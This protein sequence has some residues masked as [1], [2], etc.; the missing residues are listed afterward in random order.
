MNLCSQCSLDHIIRRLNILEIYIS[1]H[2]RYRMEVLCHAWV[3]FEHDNMTDIVN[4]EDVTTFDLD[5]ETDGKLGNLFRMALSPLFDVYAFGM[6][7]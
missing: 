2:H 3:N 1:N 4:I 7:F 6:S 5:V